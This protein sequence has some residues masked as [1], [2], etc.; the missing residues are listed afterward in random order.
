MKDLVKW[1]GSKNEKTW[2]N[3][4]EI[5][6]TVE[7]IYPTGG[8]PNCNTRTKKIVDYFIDNGNSK[9]YTVKIQY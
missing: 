1:I 4:F 6:H 3:L 7:E 5:A 9:R 8:E 2:E